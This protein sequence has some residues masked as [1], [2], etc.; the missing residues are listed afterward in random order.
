[1]NG[2]GRQ[3]MARARKIPVIFRT[4]HATPYLSLILRW[5]QHAFIDTSTEDAL[6]SN[7]IRALMAPQP[8]DVTS[9]DRHTVKPWF[10]AVEELAHAGGLPRSCANSAGPQYEYAT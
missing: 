2:F 8:V 4:L 7:H 1:M 9:S 6:V 10:N 3:T 5:P